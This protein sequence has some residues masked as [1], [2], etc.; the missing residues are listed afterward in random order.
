[1]EREQSVAGVGAA[2]AEMWAQVAALAK[3]HPHSVPVGLLAAALNDVIDAHAVR[4]AVGLRSHIPASIW[5]T[6]YFLAATAMLVM[7][8]DS[9]LTSSRN[10]LSMIALVL[11][12]AAVV[13]LIIDLDRPY[14]TMFAVS[15][16][17][18]VDLQRSIS[19]PTR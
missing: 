6:I 12:F 1:M 3:M 19:L 15:Q 8:Y 2:H 5:V 18:M 4:V 10:T 9:G 16:Q 17:A 14:Q 7:G 13:L 11:A